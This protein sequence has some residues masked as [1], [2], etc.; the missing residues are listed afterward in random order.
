MANKR[1]IQLD[2][3]RGIAILL[4]M[5][6]HLNKPTS[7]PISR[8]ILFPG[9]MFGWAGVDL[10]FVLSG[11]LVGGLILGEIDSTGG[12]EKRRFFIRRAFRLWPVL[13]VYVAAQVVIAR[14][15]PISFL[16]QILLHVQNI[17]HTPIAHLWSLAVE[18]QFYL[19][20]GLSAPLLVAHKLKPNTMVF[21]LICIIAVTNVLRSAAWLVGV[22]G[23]NLQGHM[24]FRADGLALGILLAVCRRY[25]PT[26]FEWL[27]AA[28]WLWILLLALACGGLTLIHRDM[29]YRPLLGFPLALVGSVSTILLMHGRHIPAAIMPAARGLAALGVFSYSIYIWHPGIGRIAHDRIERLTGWHNSALAVLGSYVAAVGFAIVVTRLIERPMLKI[30]DRLFPTPHAQTSAEETTDAS[31]DAARTSA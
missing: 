12:F 28:R 22:D 6:W 8:L 23:S 31:N 25:Y 5:G 27:K 9:A 21:G 29:S 7:D 17:W 4:A 13:Y 19:I 30:R 26:K 3:V 2:V 1:E 15:P 11:F 10:F 24:W 18:E 16:P 20:A 14:F